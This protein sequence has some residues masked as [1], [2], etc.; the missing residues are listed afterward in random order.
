MAKL[1]DSQKLQYESSLKQLAYEGQLIWSR[2]NN[3]LVIQTILL[4]LVGVIFSGKNQLLGGNITFLIPLSL[5]GLVTCFI[6]F[7]STSR[8]FT[9]L[10]YYSLSAREVEEK[11]HDKDLKLFKDGNLIRS[12]KKVFFYDK[13][14]KAFESLQRPGYRKYLATESSAYL[15]IFIFFLI[16]ISIFAFSLGVLL[17]SAIITS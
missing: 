12:N 7:Q 6:W 5:I 3:V 9:W 2:F 14:N 10:D 15:I 4:G 8:G 17:Y 16:Y 1:T 13:N 11:V